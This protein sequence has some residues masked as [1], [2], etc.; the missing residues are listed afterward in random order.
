MQ[1][2]RRVWRTQKAGAI[3]NLKL[4]EEKLAPL[5]AEKIRIS[6]ASVGLNFADIF[7]LTGLYSATPDGS[8]VPGLEFS[9]TVSA[10]GDS[11]NTD[12]KVGDRVYG[13]IRFGGY[14]D[15]VDVLPQHC[16]RLP[17]GWR[18]AE[19]AAFPVQSLTAYYALTDLGAVKP[20]Q[21]VLVQSA[22]GGVGLQ[23]M[24]MLREMGAV[25]IGTVSSES[26]KAFLQGLGFEEV[27]VRD[28][29]FASQLKAQLGGRPMHAVLD[30]I[31]G[32]VQKASFDALAPTGRLV[33]FGA[34]EFTPGDKPSWLKAAWLYLKRP[35][36]DVMGMIS[37]N[38]SVLA[39]N[40]IWLWQEQALFDSLLEGCAGM[41]LPA[42]HVGHEFPFEQAHE[43]IECLRSGGSVGK[44]VLNL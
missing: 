18:F 38:K 21:L 36:Y 20:G 19:G 43:A 41:G 35:R 44:V 28:R 34:A 6:V 4:V 31:G 2:S 11:A 23:A 15:T 40:L 13:C 27:I 16:R 12:L 22:A 7:A 17:D 1:E 5:E 25:P 10:I 3:H 37:D 24:R 39:F 26:K 29:D 32:A 14:A 42:P 8:F 30:G 9:G 33:V